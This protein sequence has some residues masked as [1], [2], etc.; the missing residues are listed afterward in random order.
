LQARMPT[1]LGGGIG[2]QACAL[3]QKANRKSTKRYYSHLVAELA[4]T[5]TFTTG[6]QGC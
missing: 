6:S 3:L 2:L 5:Q 1:P 4:V